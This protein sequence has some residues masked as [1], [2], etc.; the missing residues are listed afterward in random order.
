MFNSLFYYLWSN[1]R[2]SNLYYMNAF[3]RNTSISLYLLELLLISGQSHKADC[4]VLADIIPS[5]GLNGWFSPSVCLQTHCF[6]SFQVFHTLK[7]K[8]KKA[9]AFCWLEFTV[10]SK[11]TKKET[12]KYFVFATTLKTIGFL[13]T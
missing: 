13:K 2:A 1:N 10:P 5:F 7:K 4:V 9:E 6:L 8:K 12:K 3:C 11:C